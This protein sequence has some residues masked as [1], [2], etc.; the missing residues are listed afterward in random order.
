MLMIFNGV[1]PN[2][3]AKYKWIG[4]I[5]TLLTRKR[6]KTNTWFLSKRKVNRKSHVL[7][8]PNDDIADELEWP[9]PHFCVLA[10]PSFIRNG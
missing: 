4:K 6:C 10:L 5:A 3:G 7:Y 1:T 2:G 9:H 8:I